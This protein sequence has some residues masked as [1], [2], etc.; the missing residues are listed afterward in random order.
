M[1]LLTYVFIGVILSTCIINKPDYIT[2][3]YLVIIHFVYKKEKKTYAKLF[4]K[5]SA[6]AKIK[7]GAISCDQPV[8]AVM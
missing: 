7:E 5:F 1:L 2:A 6:Y 4:D 3:I 8:Y